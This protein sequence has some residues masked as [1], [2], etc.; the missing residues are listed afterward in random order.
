MMG[1]RL[2]AL[3]AGTLLVGLGSVRAQPEQVIEPKSGR[4]FPLT[5][6]VAGSQDPH[7]LVGT[8]IRTKTFLRI[9]VY[10]FGLYVDAPAAASALPAWAGR[11]AR[12]LEHD[13]SFYREL[14]KGRFGM[15]LRLLMTR[16]VIGDDMA[17][18]FDDALRPR[19][20]R[21]AA[22]LSMPGGEAALARFRRYFDVDE[23]TKESELLFSC[24]PGGTLVTSVKGEVKGE[25][26]SPALCWALFDVYLGAEPI[27]KDGKKSL[28]SRFPELLTRAPQQTPS[29]KASDQGARCE[30]EWCLRGSLAAQSHTL[31]LENANGTTL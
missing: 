6:R 13:P 11:S 7:T 14:L 31:I 23:L 3:W 9:K 27:S 19:V 29:G 20:E 26:R 4:A 17:E 15:T 22:E 24:L 10:A 8:G 21:A 18:A 1:I 2:G 12:D 16:D 5:L 30:S 28:V 25:I